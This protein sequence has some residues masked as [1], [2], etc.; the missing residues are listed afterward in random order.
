MFT[1]SLLNL[2]NHLTRLYPTQSLMTFSQT[3]CQLF[4]SRCNLLFSHKLNP[5]VMLLLN[6]HLLLQQLLHQLNPHLL[7]LVLLLLM[8]KL[9]LLLGMIQLFLLT[10]IRPL[11]PRPLTEV[12]TNT[13]QAW[14]SLPIM[15]ME[16]KKL[17]LATK[18]SDT[19]NL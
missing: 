5:K 2:L 13:I 8:T 12:R 11:L 9:T 19:Q 14:P 1:I 15:N 10:M 6:L 7:Q 16:F 3:P 17:C 4:Q 18:F